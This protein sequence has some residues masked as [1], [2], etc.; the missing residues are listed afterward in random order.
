MSFI[1][2]FDLNL[3]LKAFLIS[4][5]FFA[6][7]LFAE[8]D[9]SGAYKC[10]GKDPLNKSDYAI[11]LLVTKTGETYSFKWGGT[12]KEYSGTG[13]FSKNINNV[14]AVEF[15]NPNNQNTSGVIL[16]QV[17]PDGT[18]NGDW[19]IADQRLTG[20]EICNKQTQS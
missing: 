8:V 5:L 4:T 2:K 18:L 6:T 20:S 1:Q 13:L 7:P 15:W 3:F 19:T 16:Y 14:I 12:G 17:Q 11:D 9:I 10:M